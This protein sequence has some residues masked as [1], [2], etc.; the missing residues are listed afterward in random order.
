MRH[1]VAK[2]SPQVMLVDRNYMVQAFSSNR[3]NEPLAV[4][5]GRWRFYRSAEN[6]QAKSV[7]VFIHL[8]REDRVNPDFGHF[9][10]VSRDAGDTRDNWKIQENSR[11]F[12]NLMKAKR[13]R[14]S[15]G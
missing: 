7:Q 9:G 1:P 5:V 10:V 14:S 2:D 6:L 13:G 11:V 8:R 15:V 3:S 4:G 12:D